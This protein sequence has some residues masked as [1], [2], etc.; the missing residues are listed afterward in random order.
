MPHKIKTATTR[1]GNKRTEA[2]K[3]P[4]SVPSDGVR[5]AAKEGSDLPVSRIL[6]LQ[7]AVGNKAVQ[8]LVRAR[9]ALRL[10]LGRVVQADGRRAPDSSA[11]TAR[12][13]G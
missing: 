11:A 10:A 1:P 13:V 3:P 2:K 6:L 8:R 5:D 9:P 4:S 7:Q 12:G